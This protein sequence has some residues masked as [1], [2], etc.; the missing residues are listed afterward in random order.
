MEGIDPLDLRNSFVDSLLD[1]FN[2]SFIKDVP[3]IPLSFVSLAVTGNI[4]ALVHFRE[5]CGQVISE[6]LRGL[7]VHL[8]ISLPSVSG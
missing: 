1:P 7:A 2:L 6:L 4:A 5:I 8:S 3:I